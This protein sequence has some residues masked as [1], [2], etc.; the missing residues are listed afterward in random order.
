M[1]WNGCL[2]A[3][4]YLGGKKN[5]ADKYSFYLSEAFSYFAWLIFFLTRCFHSLI[6]TMLTW[7]R[8]GD[9]L[10]IFRFQHQG[11]EGC[12]LKFV[13]LGLEAAQDK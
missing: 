2:I 1:R 10:V 9:V 6:G 7:L 11:N 3:L 8:I 12:S 4:N 5:V 13:G